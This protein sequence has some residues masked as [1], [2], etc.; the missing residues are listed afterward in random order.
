[1]ARVRLG[2]LAFDIPGLR[3][4]VRRFGI[5][6]LERAVCLWG[7]F[8]GADRSQGLLLARRRSFPKLMPF[9]SLSQF[10]TLRP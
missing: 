7:R 6:V 8:G 9:F 10:F 4:S 3:P 1:M 5:W 2:S